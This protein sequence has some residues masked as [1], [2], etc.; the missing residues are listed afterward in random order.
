MK[1]KGLS[2][3]DLKDEVAVKGGAGLLAG[4]NSLCGG[5]GEEGAKKCVTE[6][7]ESRHTRLPFI[8]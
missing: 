8:S 5:P 2:G 4:E 3:W 7:E 6:E 1:E